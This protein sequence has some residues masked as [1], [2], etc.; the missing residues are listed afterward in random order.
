MRGKRRAQ[1][2]RISSLRWPSVGQNATSDPENVR[3]PVSWRYC[4]LSWFVVGPAFLP[5]REQSWLAEQLRSTT[6]LPTTRQSAL[7]APPIRPEARLRSSMSS[8]FLRPVSLQRPQVSFHFDLQLHHPVL[9]T[10]QLQTVHDEKEPV[11][12]QSIDEADQL[13]IVAREI[14]LNFDPLQSFHV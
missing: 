13:Q 5:A 6:R 11:T 12:L 4:G 10:S 1:Y 9:L 2:P 3:P 8:G 7:P 14:G